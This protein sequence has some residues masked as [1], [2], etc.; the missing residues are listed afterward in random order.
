[1]ARKQ[2][3]A[4]PSNAA[5]TATKDYVDTAIAAVE[6]LPGA[7]GASGAS[8][9]PGA[10]G[11]TGA[12]GASGGTGATGGTGG[13]GTTTWAGITDKPAVI[14]AG[15]DAAAARSAISAASLDGN[16]KVPVSELPNSIMEYQ[17][18]W[19]A[20]TNSPSLSDGTGSAGD[21][22]RVS[23][24]GTRNLGSGNITF[25]V[26]DYAIYNGSAWQK[27]DT[28]DAVSSVAGRTGDVTLAVADVSGAEA[29]ANKDA[30][31][32]YA[33]LNS[34]AKLALSKLA[35]TGTADS[36]TYLRGDG[37]WAPV[38]GETFNQFLLMG[39]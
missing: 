30:A 15:A 38:T 31:N 22:Y 3:G 28:T 1:M 2:L 19:N 27:A 13:P 18:T 29:T 5:D 33:G 24:A 32:G 25:D 36:T 8:G 17:G 20:S 14:A 16:G 34:S 11:P 26:G 4:A 9:A 35:T 23:V 12:T 7:S 10:T 39:A 21:V 6:L 37:A